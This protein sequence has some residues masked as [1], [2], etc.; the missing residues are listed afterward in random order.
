MINQVIT[1]YK[2]KNI[3]FSYRSELHWVYSR[4][5]WSRCLRRTGWAWRA[6]DRSG[7]FLISVRLITLF[8]SCSIWLMDSL[9]VIAM[10]VSGLFGK[11]C[12]HGYDS[13]SLKT[14]PLRWDGKHPKAPVRSSLIVAGLSPRRTLT[15][16]RHRQHLLRKKQIQG[17]FEPR[18]NGREA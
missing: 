12:S 9:T 10:C 4:R 11:L 1:I 8:P 15:T 17:S 14:G 13:S 2:K 16:E 6:C 18:W 3:N 5:N 7:T